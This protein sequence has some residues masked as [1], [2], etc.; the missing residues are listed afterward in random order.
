M[1][2]HQSYILQSILDC[3]IYGLPI[4]WVLY[5]M[6]AKVVFV[7]KWSQFH[8]LESVEGQLVAIASLNPFHCVVDAC[9]LQILEALGR[10]DW[11]CLDISWPCNGNPH[12]FETRVLFCQIV[13]AT[14]HYEDISAWLEGVHTLNICDH[15]T[16][17]GRVDASTGHPLTKLHVFAH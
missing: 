14:L 4:Q 7:R 6:I 5:Y 1:T 8:C 3:N 17:E 10:G 9:P 15:R 2:V 11:L 16:V 12:F 13:P